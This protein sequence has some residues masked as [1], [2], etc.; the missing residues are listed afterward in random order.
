M[1]T[2]IYNNF[3]LYSFSI[4]S[5]EYLTLRSDLFALIKKISGK[6]GFKSQTYFL[7]I[8]YLDILFTQNKKIDFNYNVMG[9]A[10]LLL[11]SKYCLAHSIIFIFT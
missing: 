9:L 3:S 7:S 6:M 5:K 2:N 8:Y 4:I 10:C 1:K 11:A